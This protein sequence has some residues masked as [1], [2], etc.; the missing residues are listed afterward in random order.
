MPARLK[1][2]GEGKYILKEA[3]REVIPAAVI[4]RPK[5]YFPVPALK[6]LRGEVLDF[7]R[8]GLTSAAARQRGLFRS[9]YVEELLAAPEDHITKLR[10]SKLWQL[11]LLECWLQA[12]GL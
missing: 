2:S 1:V 9:D 5:G 12:Q 10:G 4:D 6:Y 7:V 11:G 8:D 3:A